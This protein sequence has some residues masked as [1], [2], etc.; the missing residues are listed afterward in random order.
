[1]NFT[2]KNK[3]VTK[4][5]EIIPRNTK[6]TN[7]VEIAGG[8]RKRKIDDID[9]LIKTY[10]GKEQDWSKRRGTVIIDNQKKQLHYYQNNKLGKFE[11]KFK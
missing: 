9:R 7:V 8:K 5:G 3:I 1:M 4:K 10:G 11:F 2:I 6:V